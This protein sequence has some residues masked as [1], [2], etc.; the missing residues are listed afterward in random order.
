MCRGIDPRR[1]ATRSGFTLVEAV[2]VLAVFTLLLALLL[3]SVQSARQAARRTQCT[4]HLH[5]IIVSAHNYESMY[6]VFPGSALLAG[7]QWQKQLLPFLGQFNQPDAWAVPIYHC[8]S[9]PAAGYMVNDGLWPKDIN[10]FARAAPW[11]FVAA[12]DI[13]DGLSATAAFADKLKL[14]PEIADRVFPPGAYP[15]DW[16][17]RI[18]I[19]STYLGDIDAFAVE[20][21]NNALPPP[22]GGHIVWGYNHIMTP[23]QNSC[24]NGPRTDPR[25]DEWAITATSAHTGGVNVA[26]ADG[27]VRFTQDAI[28]PLVWRALGTRNGNEVIAADW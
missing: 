24:F 2:V 27:S 16:I 3:P 28:D 1:G 21:R 25:S 26:Y 15:D 7:G 12:R 13:S 18:R 9:D 22:T 5:Q 10:G 8:P 23:N 6:G 14:P 17:R 4:S 11:E 19:T 20:C